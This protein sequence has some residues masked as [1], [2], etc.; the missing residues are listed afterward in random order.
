MIPLN[1]VI[2]SIF[3]DYSSFDFSMN[4]I[5]CE[6]NDLKFCSLQNMDEYTN[7]FHI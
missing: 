1:S 3:R 5:F 7:V 2:V 6:V 4:D